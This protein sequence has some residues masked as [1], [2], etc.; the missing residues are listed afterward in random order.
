MTIFN[1][2][3]ILINSVKQLWFNKYKN[4]NFYIYNII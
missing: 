3:C 2:K 4:K 1:I